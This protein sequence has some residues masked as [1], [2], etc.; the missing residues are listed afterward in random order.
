MDLWIGELRPEGLTT[1]EFRLMLRMVLQDGE[2]NDS[3]RM[4]LQD[5][6]RNDSAS[7]AVSGMVI[8]RSGGDPRGERSRGASEHRPSS[9]ASIFD[10]LLYIS[11][12]NPIVFCRNDLHPSECQL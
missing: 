2:R 8:R 10:A 7:R 12:H 3:V 5:G 11:R 4:V 1:G 6:E 9:I